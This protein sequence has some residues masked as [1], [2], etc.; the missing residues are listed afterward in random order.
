MITFSVNDIIKVLNQLLFDKYKVR[1]NGLKYFQGKFNG[2]WDL[3][4]D[5]LLLV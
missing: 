5:K 3:L 4:R 2:K 1:E